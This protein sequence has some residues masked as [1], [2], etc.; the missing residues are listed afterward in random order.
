MFVVD[1]VVPHSIFHYNIYNI[2]IILSVNILQEIF[3]MHIILSLNIH[4]VRAKNYE[5]FMGGHVRSAE[6]SASS[7]HHRGDYSISTYQDEL[8]GEH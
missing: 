2:N 4:P 5:N 8:L 3:F 7:Y 1:V 6:S